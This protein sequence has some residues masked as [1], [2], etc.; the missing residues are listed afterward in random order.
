MTGSERVKEARSVSLPH[1]PHEYVAGMFAQTDRNC[2]HL[3][4]RG[5]L[6]FDGL[7][8]DR[9][10]MG[11]AVGHVPRPTPR[12]RL[13][14]LRAGASSRFVPTFHAL[15]RVDA[16]CN[17]ECSPSRIDSIKFHALPRVDSRVFRA[18]PS[19]SED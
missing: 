19:L 5:D 3:A 2:W 9:T 14:Q 16:S 10:K 17:S 11:M 8:A 1:K 15:P 6:A 7:T 13:G 18:M 12:G 4:I